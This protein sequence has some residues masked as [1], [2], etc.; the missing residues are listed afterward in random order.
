MCVYILKWSNQDRHREN[1][2]GL[3][4]N[5]VPHKKKSQWVDFY[6]AFWVICVDGAEY[7]PYSDSYSWARLEANSI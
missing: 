6:G 2:H 7:G 5:I 4:Q 1:S 3:R